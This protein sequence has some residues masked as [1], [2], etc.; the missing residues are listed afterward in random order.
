MNLPLKLR[1]DRVEPSE[2]KG[3]KTYHFSSHEEK[4]SVIGELPDRIVG[5][6]IGVGDEVTL[7]LSDEDISPSDLAK[8]GSPI[9]LMEGVLFRRSTSEAEGTIKYLISVHGLQFRVLSEK[10]LFPKVKTLN[11][12]ICK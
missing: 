11:I 1:V 3:I 2:V 8:F 9:V 5:G 12:A 7:I 10:D 6:K 4:V